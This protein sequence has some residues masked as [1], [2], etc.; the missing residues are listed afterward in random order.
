MCVCVWGCGHESW[1]P[2]RPVK[3]VGVP[4]TGV[5]GS[6]GL[7][8]IVARR[9]TAPQERPV[10]PTTEPPLQLHEDRCHSTL[11]HFLALTL[12]LLPLHLFSLSLV[13]VDVCVCVGGCVGGCLRKTIAHRVLIHQ[14]QEGS[15]VQQDNGWCCFKL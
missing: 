4:G 3:G 7:F 5:S 12:C 8:D 11:S 14:R 9:G 6:C 13:G 2:R 15:L 10:L 1:C